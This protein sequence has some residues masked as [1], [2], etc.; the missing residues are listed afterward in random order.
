MKANESLTDRGITCKY[1]GSIILTI[2]LGMGINQDYQACIL[3]CNQFKCKGLNEED[4][5]T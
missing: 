1:R 3:A 5:G 4:N 2:R